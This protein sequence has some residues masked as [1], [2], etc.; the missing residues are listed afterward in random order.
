MRRGGSIRSSKSLKSR[1][2]VKGKSG[3]KEEGCQK[4]VKKE[5][6]ETL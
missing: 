6:V 4:T 5:V 1:R 3:E 2:G